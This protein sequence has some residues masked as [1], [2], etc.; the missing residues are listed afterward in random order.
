MEL[1]NGKYLHVDDEVHFTTE[2]EVRNRRLKIAINCGWT[3]GGQCVA[4]E[5]EK[6]PISLGRHAP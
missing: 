3:K 1:S 2:E 6:T 5:T 4:E